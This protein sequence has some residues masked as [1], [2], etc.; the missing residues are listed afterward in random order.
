MPVESAKDIQ[1]YH[2]VCFPDS[3]PRD[4]NLVV[5]DRVVVSN[6]HERRTER[7]CP[8]RP[9]HQATADRIDSAAGGDGFRRVATSQ[10]GDVLLRRYYD[11][12]RLDISSHFLGRHSIACGILLLQDS[13]LR[14]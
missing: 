4:V 7:E 9:G 10:I 12:W 14:F 5:L 13:A 2:K 3:S 1:V 8:V 11:V 6:H